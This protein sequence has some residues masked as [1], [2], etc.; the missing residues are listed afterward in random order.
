MSAA[1]EAMRRERLT[2]AQVQALKALSRDRLHRCRRGWGV[3]YAASGP[4]AEATVQALERKGLALV[5]GWAGQ[6]GAAEITP[7]GREALAR[8]E[9][10]VG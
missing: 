3:T 7:A 6:R 10:A 9:E 4:Y 1:V 2:L 8:I 5:D